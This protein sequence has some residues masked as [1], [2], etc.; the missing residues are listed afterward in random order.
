MNF[1]FPYIGNFIIPIVDSSYFS[2]RGGE[3]P[4]T[5]HLVIPTKYPIIISSGWWFGTWILFS[6]ILGISSSQ[7]TI[8]HIFQDGVA[9]NHQPVISLSQLS[10]PSLSHLV[11][12]LEHEFYFPI[13]WEFHHPNW[14]FVIFFRTGW[15]KTTNQFSIF[16]YIWVMLWIKG[17]RF[18][19]HLIIPT[20]YPI[21]I[22]SSP[23]FS[24]RT[25]RTVSLSRTGMIRADPAAR[26][27]CHLRRM[28]DV[29][30]CS[31]SMVLNQP[32]VRWFMS[33]YMFISSKIPFLEM[34]NRATPT[35]LEP[36]MEYP[37]PSQSAGWYPN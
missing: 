14:R 3:K 35:T 12:G 36:P 10:I 27:G 8:R 16:T 11:G 2:G 34:V 24:G 23:D 31:T 20:K 13:Y 6:H 26:N 22:S 18:L 37:L 21:I 30:G 1:I 5:S 15:R 25:L 19:F 32:K 7:L 9:K 17:D 28:E 29:Y 4:P 33:I